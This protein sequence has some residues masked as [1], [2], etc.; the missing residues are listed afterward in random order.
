MSETNN[1]ITNPSND[2]KKKFFKDSNM[3]VDINMLRMTTQGEYSVSSINASKKLI[4]IITKYFRTT[5]ITV[6]DGTG[7][8]GADTIALAGVFYKVNSIELDQ[9]NYAVLENNVKVYGLSNVKLYLGN[10]LDL[11]DKIKQD[12]IYIDAP[13]GGRDYKKLPSVR[14]KLGNMEISDIVKKFRTKAKLFVFKVPKN[15]DFNYFIANSTVKSCFVQGYLEDSRVKFYF[16]VVPMFS[17]K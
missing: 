14:L 6:T 5:D 15:Y 9:T 1:V 16:L 12:V 3:V 7:N 4:K 17:S 11:L 2:F 13:W 8:N 10:T